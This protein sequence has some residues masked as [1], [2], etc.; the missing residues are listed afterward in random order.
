MNRLERT[1]RG[2]T[3]SVRPISASSKSVEIHHCKMKK[4][5]LKAPTPCALAPGARVHQRHEATHVLYVARE[6]YKSTLIHTMKI[7]LFAEGD[8]LVHTV[9]PT[10]VML[11]KFA[12][13]GAVSTIIVP[14]MKSVKRCYNI[15]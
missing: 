2:S 10:M 8:P 5:V 14:R 3:R 11:T 13:V 4:N 1:A 15:L 6:G 12:K 7:F 9:G